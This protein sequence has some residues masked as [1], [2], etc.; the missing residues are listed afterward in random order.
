MS[1]FSYRLAAAAFVAMLLGGPLSVLAADLPPPP[2]PPQLRNDWTQLYIGGTVGIGCFQM[3][4]IPSIGPDP[5]L[6]GCNVMGGVLGGW[7]Y[8][9]NNNLVIGGEG[10]FMWGGSTAHNVLDAVSYRAD[11]FRSLRGR[12]GWLDG[13]TLF[14]ATGGVG[15]VSG[16]MSGLVGPSSIY[17]KDSDIHTGW[18]VGAGIEHA[19]T[20]SLHARLEYLY[21]TFNKRKYDLSVST[22]TP[23]CIVGLKMKDLHLVRAAV[24]WNFGSLLW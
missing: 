11:D 7:T 5:E 6:N 1:K 10:D 12:I 19:F 17:A 13:D 20:P 21:G 18:V 14:Y 22:C 15:W 9:F 2:P 3:I 16:T 4:Y 24:T 23:T 8:Q